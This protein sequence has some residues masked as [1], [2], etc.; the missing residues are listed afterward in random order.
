MMIAHNIDSLSWKIL[1]FFG[2]QLEGKDNIHNIFDPVGL[3][4]LT[5]LR[6]GLS[7][8]RWKQK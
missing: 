3:K 2:R 6:L 4:L 7:Q 5:R 8:L 1:S